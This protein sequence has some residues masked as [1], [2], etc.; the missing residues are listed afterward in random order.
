MRKFF[1]AFAALVL[2]SSLGV[3]SAQTATPVPDPKPDLSPMMYLV[4]TWTC[5]SQLPDRPGDRVETQTWKVSM[6]G[7]YLQQHTE[8]PSFDTMRGRAIVGENYLTYDPAT[9]KWVIISVDNFGG[10]GMSTSPGP[11][12]NTI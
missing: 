2:T 4:G 11:T 12:G 8:S 9:K 3:A 1:V 7:R 10:Y 6:D 5:H